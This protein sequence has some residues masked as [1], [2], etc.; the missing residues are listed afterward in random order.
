MTRIRLEIAEG[1]SVGTVFEIGPEQAAAAIGRGPTN[2]FV[3]G[4]SSLETNTQCFLPASPAITR[5]RPSSTSTT[6]SASP[7][8]SS[9]LGALG[10][11][12]VTSKGTT[13]TPSET[14][15]VCVPRLAA[16]GMSSVIVVAS[17]IV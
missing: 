16:S 1:D 7:L 15:M 9:S 17:T 4:V 14:L 6:F 5:G 11:A 8:P 2:A 3:L 10:A 13:S 12:I